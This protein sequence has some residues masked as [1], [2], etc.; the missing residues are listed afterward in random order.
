MHHALALTPQGCINIKVIY[1]TNRSFPLCYF[2]VLLMNERNENLLLLN[3]KTTRFKG[4]TVLLKEINP[5][6]P[7]GV[8]NYLFIC[9]T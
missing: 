5:Y 2:H 9:L 7:G 1:L 3:S 4:K 6:K 8:S